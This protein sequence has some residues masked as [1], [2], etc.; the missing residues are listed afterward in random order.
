MR[1]FT[2]I[3]LSLATLPL[4]LLATPAPA[5]A[6]D[7][8]ILLSPAAIGQIFC[9]GMVGNDMAPVAGLITAD[10]T[11]AIADSQ[12]RSDAW[13]AKNPGDKPPLGDGIPW[14]IVPDYAADCMVGDVVTVDGQALVT[15]NYGF[16]EYPDANTSDALTLVAVPDPM[17]GASRW[18]ID[19]VVYADDYDLRRALKLAFTDFE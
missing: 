6:Q 12:A 11:A 3:A 7:G 19:N 5:T 8:P 2:L 18:R 15:V 4:A 13:A 16:P 17:I 1:S 14:S 9:L 10:L